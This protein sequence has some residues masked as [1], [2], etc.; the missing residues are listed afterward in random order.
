[1]NLYT[2]SHAAGALCGTLLTIGAL[3]LYQLRIPVTYTLITHHAVSPEVRHTL[4]TLINPDILTHYTVSTLRELLIK[5]IPS[6]DTVTIRHAQPYQPTITI[7]QQDACAQ[8]ND[9]TLL[10]IDGSLISATTFVESYRERLPRIRL[11]DTVDTP[12]QRRLCARY[13]QTIPTIIQETYHIIWHNKTE[14]LLKHRIE[15]AITLITHATI[16]WTAT[17]MNAIKQCIALLRSRIHHPSTCQSS[18]LIDIRM[19]GYL[20]VHP[21]P[22]SKGTT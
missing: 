9:K 3:M 7:T 1:M 21:Y 14:I 11:S 19:P 12:E 18:W 4:K 16:I 13:I 20:V 22:V 10:G 8:L 6:I 15:S 5:H 17:Q 2:S